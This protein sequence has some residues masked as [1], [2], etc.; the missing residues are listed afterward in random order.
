M[1]PTTDT[2]GIS[3][4][5]AERMIL[6]VTLTEG[7]KTHRARVRLASIRPDARAAFLNG[8]AVDLGNRYWVRRL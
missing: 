8:L 6:N 7:R 4:Q 5:D 3:A 1:T 2:T